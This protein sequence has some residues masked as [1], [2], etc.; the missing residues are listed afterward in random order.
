M[1]KNIQ[2]SPLWDYR[3]EK[4]PTYSGAAL[5][6]IDNFAPAP[7]HYNLSLVTKTKGEENSSPFL[8]LTVYRKTLR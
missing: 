7:W 4:D 8:H 6:E 2:L 3:H 1:E 5:V